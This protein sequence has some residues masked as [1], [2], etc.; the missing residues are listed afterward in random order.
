MNI[1]ENI[2]NKIYDILEDI[3]ASPLMRESFIYTWW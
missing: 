1:S 2:A 3:G